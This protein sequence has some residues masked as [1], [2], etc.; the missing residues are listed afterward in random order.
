MLWIGLLLGAL[1]PAAAA[2]ARVTTVFVGI[3]TTRAW[4]EPS[5]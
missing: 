3:E 1:I 4:S 5:P 2:T